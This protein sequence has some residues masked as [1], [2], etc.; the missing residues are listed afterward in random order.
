MFKKFGNLFIAFVLLIGL[1]GIAWAT[2]TDVSAI[3]LNAT[4]DDSYLI[5]GNNSSGTVKFTVDTSGNM[6][7]EG[8]LDY[9]GVLKIAGASIYNEIAIPL[10]AFTLRDNST[11]DVPLS[12]A[13]TPGYEIDDNLPG[14]VWADGE[15]GWIWT[16]FRVPPWYS[17]GGTIVCLTTQAGVSENGLDMQMYITSDGTSD[18][19]ATGYRPTACGTG[20]QEPN[21][22]SIT[23]S[24]TLTAGQ[25]A[26]LMLA[27]EDTT[28][29][30]AHDFEL[31]GVVFRGIG[32]Y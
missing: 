14:I 29:T 5:Y 23:I 31:R 27:R 13:T 20:A 22:V 32:K 26:T 1:W 12:A 16:T 8:N 28:Y 10:D 21:E 17:S 11:A 3:R 6:D 24:D 19:T 2:Y 9:N 7:I 18:A 30:G 15:A 4:V 25:W